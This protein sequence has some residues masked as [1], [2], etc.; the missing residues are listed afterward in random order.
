MFGGG[1]GGPVDTTLY[2]T[3]NVS[4]S[5]TQAEIKKS[6]FKLAKEYHPDKNPDHGD[7]FKEI[8]F[9]YEI[10]SKPETR[11]LYDARGLE[12]IKEGG[13]GGGFPGGNLFSH[14]FGRG[15]MDDDDDEIGGHPFN[16]FGGMGGGRQHRRKH[17]DTVHVLQ[18]TL[19]DLY[20]GKTTK[21]KLTRKSLCKT[22]EGSGGQKGQKYKCET[23]KGRGV[24]MIIQQIG[25]GM[26]QQMQTACE[27]CRGTG[28]KV[29]DNQKCKTCK[30][31]RFEENQI[32][33]E[34][35]VTPGTENNAKITFTGEGDHSDPDVEPG[36][37]VIVIQ[38]K[39]HPLF[40][41]DGDDLHMKKKITLNEALCG[42]EFIV[43]HLDGHPLI[44]RGQPGEIIEPDAVKGVLARGMPNK[45]RRDEKGD[46]F[47]HF[48]IEFPEDHFLANESGYALLRSLLPIP[49][50]CPVPPTAIEVSLMEYD[51]KKYSRGRGGDAYNE[52]S[53]EDG[54]G[55][56][57]HHGPGVSC[58]QQ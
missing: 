30:G 42:F 56:R 8:S 34:V 50:P 26:I 48:E 13:S 17:K 51:E 22:C 1:G 12:G 31:E 2:E 4:P 19:E 47:V 27:P 15:G 37:V 11:Q 23:C 16:I 36:D 5:A 9:A 28:G 21:L 58:Q 57:I 35:Y 45:R 24:R 53:D 49:R 29:P 52:D 20:N 54:G 55:P 43:K 41:R 40:E 32:I 3:L 38:Q 6:Y 7:K 18:M 44:I 25:P 39:D 33:I 46:L 10:L 14:F